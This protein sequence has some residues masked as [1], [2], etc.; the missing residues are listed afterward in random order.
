MTPILE[1]VARRLHSLGGGEEALAL[2]ARV[3]NADDAPPAPWLGLVDRH[4][5]ELLTLAARGQV[6]RAVVLSREHLRDFPDDAL[7]A[8][9]IDVLEA[10]ENL[11]DEPSLPA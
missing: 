6:E 8:A 4:R 10:G 9:L 1:R 3:Q 5:L 7:I 11:D 2:V